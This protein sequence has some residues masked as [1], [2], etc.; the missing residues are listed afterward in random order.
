MLSWDPGFDNE[1]IQGAYWI[2]IDYMDQD[3]LESTTSL[4]LLNL[5]VWQFEHISDIFL[6]YRDILRMYK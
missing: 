5:S 2:K 1:L 6:F 4:Y 3:L